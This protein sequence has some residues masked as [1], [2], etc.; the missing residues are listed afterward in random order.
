[1]EREEL[2][3]QAVEI[4]HKAVSAVS[5]ILTP[6]EEEPE[7]YLAAINKMSD[8]MIRI[9]TNAIT[10]KPP[11]N[12]EPPALETI[13]IGIKQFEREYAANPIKARRQYTGKIVQV[14]ATMDEFEEYLANGASPSTKDSSERKYMYKN[15]FMAIPGEVVLMNELTRKDGTNY[16]VR[17]KGNNIDGKQWEL[18]AFLPKEAS[19]QVENITTGQIIKVKGHYDGRNENENRY[20][21]RDCELLG[22]NPGKKPEQK[23][24]RSAWLYITM[25]AI[26]GAIVYYFLSK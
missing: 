19:K 22:V 26:I 24:S 2:E 8:N 11:V 23:K 13:E 9:A 3:N 25:A 18:V 4:L 14:N 10:P 1:M 21:L 17:F 6:L 20:F 16:E 7:E 12:D 5:E 15:V